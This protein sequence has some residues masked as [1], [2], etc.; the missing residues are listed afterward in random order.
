MVGER[1]KAYSEHRRTALAEDK[2]IK[3]LESKLTT[4]VEASDE[5]CS[6]VSIV[7]ARLAGKDARRAQM[8]DIWAL[9]IKMMNYLGQGIDNAMIQTSTMFDALHTNLAAIVEKSLRAA[10]DDLINLINVLVCACTV[11]SPLTTAAVPEPSALTSKVITPPRPLLVNVD[12]APSLKPR[13][14]LMLVFPNSYV[15]SI[16]LRGLL[17]ISVASGF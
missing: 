15:T 11:T 2:R 1:Q 17:P 12:T 8:K 6:N 9:V 16:L 10:C 5:A 13:L 7:N 3:K 4:A 14:R